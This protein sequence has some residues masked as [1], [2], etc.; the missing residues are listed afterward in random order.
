M[1][2]EQL[3]SDLLDVYV[4]PRPSSI[5]GIGIFAVRDIP[6]GCRNMFS[7][8]NDEWIKV[9]VAEVEELP[10]YAKT[11]VHTYCTYDTEFYY[12]EKYGLKKMDIVSFLNHSDKP[13]LAVID[14]GEFFETTRDI[15]SGEELFLDYADVAG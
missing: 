9:P 5:H 14:N 3:I 6:K 13:N 11:L 7:K 4:I 12:V 15:K 10:E 2:K 1:T 8:G